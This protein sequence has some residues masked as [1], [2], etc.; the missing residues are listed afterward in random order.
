MDS[1]PCGHETCVQT[2]CLSLVLSKEKKKLAMTS[3]VKKK[4]RIFPFDDYEEE[5]GFRRRKRSHEPAGTDAEGGRDESFEYLSCPA[6]KVFCLEAKRCSYDCGGGRDDLEP[7]EFEDED[8]DFDSD[9]DDDDDPDSYIRCPAGSTF[10]MSEM[11]CS[12]KC[13]G[14][15]KFVEGIEEDDDI[16]IELDYEPTVCPAGQVFCLQVMACVSNCGFFFDEEDEGLD[17]DITDVTCPEGLVY[18]MTSNSCIQ[19]EAS[20]TNSD[21]N[22]VQVGRLNLEHI[23]YVFHVQ[24]P[25]QACPPGLVWC[26]RGQGCQ[27]TCLDTERCPARELVPTQAQSTCQVAA[28]C[29]DNSSCCTD[30]EGFRQCVPHDLSSASLEQRNWTQ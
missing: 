13:D 20:C 16:D 14:V 7:L 12:T 27:A 30:D 10:C 15:D 28:H 19:S 5:Y 21:G 1:L 2:Q 25:D 17:I 9:Y 6:G 18:C 11:K 24:A 4:R 23:L 26:G 22:P 8:E 3:A 29:P